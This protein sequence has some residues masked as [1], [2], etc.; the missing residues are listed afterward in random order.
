MKN[1]IQI[2]FAVSGLSFWFFL[3]FPFANYHESYE[4]I[5]QVQTIPEWDLIFSH[6]GH[7]VCYRP[8]GQFLAILLYKITNHSILAIQLGNFIFSILGILFIIKPYSKK[9]WPLILSFFLIGSLF[10]PTFNYLFHLN[11]FFY[12]PLAFLL[13][14]LIYFTLREYSINNIVKSYLVA[15]MAALFHPFAI[16][17]FIAFLAGWTFENKNSV[18][19][20]IVILSLIL[21]SSLI[22]LYFILVDLPFSN[23]TYGNLAGTYR[24]LASLE[25][26]TPTL[27]LSFLL[28]SVTAY[29]INIVRKSKYI[30]LG[31][32]VF[33]SV[34]FVY[35]KI[36]LIILFILT[37]LIKLIYKKKWSLV[38][39]MFI[40]L[41]FPLSV[42]WISSSLKFLI[43]Y[44]LPVAIAID[45]KWTSRDIQYF[46]KKISFAVPITLFIILILLKSSVQLPVISRFTNPIL[47]EREKT[48]QLEDAIEW[49][50]HSDDTN[51][52]VEFLASGNN[53][54]FP[55]SSTNINTY[56]E[57]VNP[58]KYG[59]SVKVFI[60]FDCESSNANNTLYE[61]EG[62]YSKNIHMFL[63]KE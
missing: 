12:S 33:L 49:L 43:L 14:I 23:L 30:L 26:N 22:I 28:S 60:C 17:I 18:T 35:F 4:W 56:L 3:G 15:I 6:V 2:I 41:S 8:L 55:A 5:A 11:G 9:K 62:L 13:G 29:T 47:T 10:Y 1:P 40:L 44:L 50:R 34:L 21:I 54:R 36:P 19:Q 32:S 7:F 59:K 38:F 53:K 16:V 20:R 45:V 61:A 48:F 25:S 63:L 58:T 46:I 57:K 37:C 27:L 51:F 39:L 52:T 31:L 24:I 42:G